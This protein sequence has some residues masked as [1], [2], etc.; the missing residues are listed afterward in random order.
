MS[1]GDIDIYKLLKR[2]HLPTIA[3]ML[4]EYETRAA[5]EGWS[6]RDF[7]ALLVA[8]EVAHRNDTRIHKSA[9]GAHFPFLKTIEEFDF[10]FQSSLRRQQLGPFLAP[11]FVTEGRN[12]ILS[13]RPGRGKTHLAIAVAYKAIQNGFDARFVTASDLIDELSTASAQGRLREATQAYVNPGVLVID[14]VGYLHHAPDAANVLYGVVDRRSLRR[15]PMVFTTNKAL[16][17]WGDVLHDRELAEALLDRVLERG[18]H[19]KLGG[20]SYRTRDADPADLPTEDRPEP[21][22]S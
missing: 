16:G 9:R 1:P 14:E 7:L 5:A 17:S 13:G 12:L 20:K 22:G 2:L 11:E 8:E 19:I 10:V 3:R 18:A 15:R 4:A 6:H 21:G